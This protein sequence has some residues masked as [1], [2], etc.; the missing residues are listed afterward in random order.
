MVNAEGRKRLLAALDEAWR[1]E[2][3]IIKKDRIK[4]DR[5]TDRLVDSLCTKAVAPAE[6]LVAAQLSEV[7]PQGSQPSK[8]TDG[9][10]AA[11]LGV[12]EP[13]V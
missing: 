4:S 9:A 6:R 5:E 11:A 3:E 8:A 2:R 12:P 10:L 1:F 7:P 13:A